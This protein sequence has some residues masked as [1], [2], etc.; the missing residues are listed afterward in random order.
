ML[1][2]KLLIAILVSV[3]VITTGVLVPTVMLSGDSHSM[4]VT[5]MYS[6]SLEGPWSMTSS[7]STRYVEEITVVDGQTTIVIQEADF[8]WEAPEGTLVFVG[9]KGAK[10]DTGP[11]DPREQIVP[12]LMML[13]QAFNPN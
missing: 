4:S 11:Q 8:M 3:V 7:F 13:K 1:R 5:R 10:G 9:K 6:D 12:I 2:K